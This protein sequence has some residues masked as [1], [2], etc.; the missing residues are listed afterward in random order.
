MAEAGQRTP[1]NKISTPIINNRNPQ[2][3]PNR[4]VPARQA[5]TQQVKQPSQQ[6][7]NQY[8]DQYQ[9]QYQDESNDQELYDDYGNQISPQYSQRNQV[10]PPKTSSY[11]NPPPLNDSYQ[12]QNSNVIGNYTKNSKN[13]LKKL[14]DEIEFFENSG[15]E[16]V[17]EN[18]F[19]S[20]SQVSSSSFFQTREQM[21]TIKTIRQSPVFNIA[22]N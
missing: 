3:Q 6:Y 9:D 5:N 20:S 18:R 8:D 12:S 15:N 13:N 21:N 2:A 16:N 7:Q 19:E 22:V 11:R 17:F 4:Y 10:I 1:S 14:E